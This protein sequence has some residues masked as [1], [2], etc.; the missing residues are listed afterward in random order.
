M[1]LFK[2]TLL[3]QAL[4]VA[5]T[6]MQVNANSLYIEEVVITAQKRSENVQDVP[7]AISAFTAENMSN[8][9]METANDIA[10][11][12]PNLQV[13]SPYGETQP[14]FSIRGQSMSDYNTNQSSPV[15]VYVDEAYIGANFL[16]GMALFD[17]ERVEVLRGPQGT[18][19]GKNTTGGAINFISRAPGLDGTGGEV[20]TTFGDYGREHVDAAA[21]TEIIEGRLGVRAAYTYTK[22]DGHHKNHFPGGDDLSSVDTWAGR[23]TL[24]YEG[25]GMDATFRYTS[26]DNEG[27]ATAVV[28]EG[29]ISV[30]GVGNTDAVGL[31]VGQL[32]RQSGWD[33]WEGS[34]NKAETYRTEFDTAMLTVNWDIGD[35]TLTTVT[36]Y[37]K[38]KGLNQADTDGAPWKLLEI[39]WGTEVKQFSQDLRIASDFD[40]P[41]NFIGG[42]YYAKDTSDVE[43]I[44]E[45]LHATGDLGVPF[46]PMN[47]VVTNPAA[48]AAT[49]GITTIQRYTQERDSIALYLHTTYDITDQWAL[50]AGLRYTKDEG[51]GND[52]H[53]QLA[54]YD[55]NPV[56]D[57]IMPGSFDQGAA[58]YNDSEF[59][60]KIGLDYQFD[61][62]LMI[63]TS[64]SRGYRSSAFNGGAQFAANEV[65]VAA[66]EFVDA[67]EAG[68]KSQLL[69]GSIQF[70][71]AVFYYDYTDQQFVNLIGIQQFLQNGDKSTIKG[72]E[73]EV[74]SRITE[75]LTVNAGLGY[76]NTEFK[77][78]TLSD[79]VN[80]GDI[81]LDGNELFNA[82]ELNFNLAVDYVITDNSMG[83]LSISA[84]TVY[85]SEQWFSAYNDDLNYDEIKADSSWMSNAKL[86]WDSVDD[87][88]SIALWVKNIEN[89]DEPSFAINTQGGFGF[90]Y[91]TVGLPRRMGVDVTYRF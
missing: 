3:A 26:G 63:Y 29:R 59:T 77:E 71:G 85:T 31:L 55:R 49:S 42:I 39:D 36:S 48:N 73:L 52:L 66:P 40:G 24:R 43:N 82:P 72:F 32:T 57:L 62:D 2:K 13:S 17:L 60:G 14:I 88:I 16:Q 10:S 50:T 33:A 34:H 15:G 74:I 91:Y 21:E 35:Y 7:V 47:N 64:Y 84:D 22:T 12:V 11:G 27:S 20:T 44:F 65:G 41:F 1:K 38:G 54:D 89:N 90:D 61:E 76:L 53:T 68:F 79:T 58:E 5:C 56:G 18:L 51:N 9:K 37:L 8:M 45:L 86:S 70:N 83:V 69:E 67:Y 25:E 23:I 28:S 30:P 80:G 6:S 81:E 78:L 4:L 19:Y 46:S 75:A 87:S